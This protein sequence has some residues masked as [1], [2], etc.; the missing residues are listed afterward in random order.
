MVDYTKFS[1]VKYRQYEPPEDYRRNYFID[2]FNKISFSIDLL[3]DEYFPKKSVSPV[4]TDTYTATIYDDVILCNGTFSVNLYDAG[5]QTDE[6]G[7]KVNAGRRLVIKNTGT[8]SITV[9]G[10]STQTIDGATTKVL[11]SQYD[12]VEIVS[13]GANWHIIFDEAA[14][15]V[16]SFGT[17]THTTTGKS[18]VLGF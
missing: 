17:N 18:L 4:K 16:S 10:S 3:S 12:V 1:N 6:V 2:E 9:D 15:V 7:N 14:A 13:D 5:G 8:G 11:S